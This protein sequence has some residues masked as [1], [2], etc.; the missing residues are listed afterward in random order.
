MGSGPYRGGEVRPAFGASAIEAGIAAAPIVG[1]RRRRLDRHVR[2]V[3][4]RRWQRERRR[5]G[6]GDECGQMDAAQRRP[7]RTNGQW[8]GEDLA[9]HAGF[10]VP[11][12]PPHHELARSFGAAN[13]ATHRCARACGPF[14][15][16]LGVWRLCGRRASR[17]RRRPARPRTGVD[18]GRRHAPS[19]QRPRRDRNLYRGKDCRNRRRRQNEA[20]PGNA[21]NAMGVRWP[22]RRESPAAPERALL[23][24]AKFKARP[25][26]PAGRI[27]GEPHAGHRIGHAVQ[28]QGTDEEACGQTPPA[29]P[30]LSCSRHA[31]PL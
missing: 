16:G 17:R 9:E 15:E 21:E 23:M 26:D 13:F 5:G 29:S 11:A 31:D 28:E 8:P 25:I 27:G 4:G 19:D 30:P 7:R 2:G 10:P 12:R 1:L 20:G 24:P 6:D 14:I 22:G 18:R 3:G